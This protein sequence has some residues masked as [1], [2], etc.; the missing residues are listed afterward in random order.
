MVLMA[1]RI[2]ESRSLLGR[3]I[4]NWIW[5][6]L[7]KRRDLEYLVYANSIADVQKRPKVFD[8]YLTGEYVF[9]GISIP[10]Y[11]LPHGISV[12]VK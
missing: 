3:K 1:S 8:S 12:V 5:E 10:V 4:P 7:G 9:L 6:R 2:R 11:R